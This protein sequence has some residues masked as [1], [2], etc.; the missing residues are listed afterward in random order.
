MVVTAEKV[1]HLSLL[2][3]TNT[4][5]SRVDAVVVA[6]CPHHCSMTAVTECVGY[7]MYPSRNTTMPKN[8]SPKQLQEHP[9][10]KQYPFSIGKPQSPQC[11]LF[12]TNRQPETLPLILFVHL[13]SSFKAMGV[14]AVV[15][16]GLAA[17]GTRQPSYLP[18]P[19]YCL[20]VLHR[21]WA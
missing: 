8:K 1:E 5:S 21:H 15:Q 3:R 10:N 11:L 6:S 9:I 16:H 13:H 14:S 18:L 4:I 19:P 2:F 20:P 12:P 17:P 7:R